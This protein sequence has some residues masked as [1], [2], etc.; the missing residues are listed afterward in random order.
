MTAL[1]EAQKI[2]QRAANKRF[3][4]KNKERLRAEARAKRLKNLE[5][6]RERARAYCAVS[7]EKAAE[8]RKRY[9]EKYPERVRASKKRWLGDNP[10]YMRAYYLRTRIYQMVAGCK[11]RA[12]LEKVPFSITPQDVVVPAVCPVLGIAL[13]HGGGVKS[14]GFKDS[15][16]SLDRV[17]P[18]L[19]YVLGN[20]RV[21]SWRANRL[22]ADATAAELMKVA[23][24]A[25]AETGQL[26][27]V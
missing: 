17:V 26:E 20:V 21:I 13:N 5:A 7:P 12:D 25:A 19:G 6:E 2:K 22:K 24:Y 15:S 27:A 23:L 4:A 14:K 9:E 18:S 8:R 3:Y 16:P 10:E 1:T 11:R